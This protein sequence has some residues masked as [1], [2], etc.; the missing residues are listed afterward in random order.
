M[1]PIRIP[2]PKPCASGGSRQLLAMIQAR[3]NEPE[4]RN[5]R[6]TGAEAYGSLPPR[7]HLATQHPQDE[8]VLPQKRHG[9]HPELRR[10]GATIRNSVGTIG[11]KISTGR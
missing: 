7:D 2:C 9:Q 11:R 4:Q 8:L 5:E 10:T 3:R 6:E 1:I